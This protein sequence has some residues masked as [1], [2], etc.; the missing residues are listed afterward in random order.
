MDRD[1]SRPMKTL[2][3]LML[4]HEPDGTIEEVGDGSGD[5]RRSRCDWW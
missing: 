4:G 5:L 3:R 2:G 1:V